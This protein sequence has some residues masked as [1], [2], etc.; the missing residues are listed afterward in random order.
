MKNRSDPMPDLPVKSWYRIP[1]IAYYL[2]VGDSTIRRWIDH[3][4]LDASKLGGSVKISRESIEKFV[5][6]SKVDPFK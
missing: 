2:D 5:E 4:K 3:G 1:E 6:N